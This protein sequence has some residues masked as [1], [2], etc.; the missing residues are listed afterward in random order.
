MGFFTAT[1]NPFNGILKT[2]EN[3]E[4][5]VFGKYYSLPALNDPRIGE[6]FCFISLFV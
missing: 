1:E 2:L 6:W 5:G 3:P 4:G